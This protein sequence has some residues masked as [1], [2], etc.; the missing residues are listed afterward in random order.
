MVIRN[1][2]QDYLLRMIQ[3]LAAVVARLLG[4]R[5]GGKVDEALEVVRTA[6]GELLGPLAAAATAVDT[7]TAAQ[8]IG[9]PV[10]IAAWARLLRAR[11]ELLRDAGEH[12]AAEGVAARAAELAGE[13]RARAE[14]SRGIVES[15]L[16]EGDAEPPGAS[17]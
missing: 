16:A 11:A 15:V 17:G 2:Q 4:L 3:Q 12:E 9:E 8:I 7:A 1:S 5:G 13:A 14:G 6:E 10:R